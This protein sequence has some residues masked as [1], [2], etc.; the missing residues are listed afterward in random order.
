M[1]VWLALIRLPD[2]GHSQSAHELTAK[3]RT[4]ELRKPAPSLFAGEL[5]GSDG[6]GHAVLVAVFHFGPDGARLVLLAGRSVKIRQIKLRHRGWNG[7]GW[8]GGDGVIQVNGLSVPPR[9]P[10]EAGQ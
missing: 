6:T 1:S 10:V 7:G 2:A 5:L 4:G 3:A 8:L 9:L